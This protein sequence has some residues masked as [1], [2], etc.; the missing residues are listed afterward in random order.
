MKRKLILTVILFAIFLFTGLF[1]SDKTFAA[2]CQKCDG[3]GL[4]NGVSYVGAR[5][6]PDG[7]DGCGYHPDGVG[8]T[9]FNVQFDWG[10]E[11]SD[12]RCSTYGLF[13]CKES[14]QSCATTG[15]SSL[16]SVSYSTSDDNYDYFNVYISNA[17]WMQDV[18]GK[19]RRRKD[20]I[21]IQSKALC[22][23]G[24]D[25]DNGKAMYSKK[26]S[27][28]VDTDIQRKT[29]PNLK[30][31]GGF[32][33]TDF[34]HWDSVCKAGSDKT[35][36]L[37]GKD[38][39]EDMSVFAY[40]I[41]EPDDKYN[42][43]CSDPRSKNYPC[44][45]GSSG[46][47]GETTRTGNSSCTRLFDVDTGETLNECY[48]LLDNFAL[49]DKDSEGNA[50][51]T[52]TL[53]VNAPCGWD[54]WRYTNV[55]SSTD[56]ALL[57]CD[58]N[59]D[60]TFSG[61]QDFSAGYKYHYQ[62]IVH[63]VDADWGNEVSAPQVATV[64]RGGWYSAHADAPSGYVG[65]DW[66]WGY[67]VGFQSLWCPGITV[68]ED[69]EITAYVRR[70]YTLTG[71]AYDLYEQKW[72][73]LNGIC[74]DSSSGFL[75]DWLEVSRSDFSCDRNTL[76]NL[77]DWVGW[78]F[79]GSTC[80]GEQGNEC[81]AVL[82]ADT[83]V[84]AYYE[85]K[86]WEGRI[87][88]SGNTNIKVANSGDGY[89]SQSAEVTGYMDNCENG[90]N[91]TFDSYIKRVSGSGSTK[92]HV[93]RTSSNL[94]SSP[95]AISNADFGEQ[96]GGDLYDKGV[97]ELLRRD[98]ALTM[99]PGMFICEEMTFDANYTNK[100]VHLRLCVFA[101]G[102]AQ[103]NDPANVDTPENDPGSGNLNGD[104][105][106]INIKVKNE[107]VAKWVQY[108]RSVWAKPPYSGTA[109]DRLAYRSSYNP[110]LQYTYYLKLSDRDMPKQFSIDGAGA[111]S[112]NG[113]TIGTL[114]NRNKTPSWNNAYTI[115]RN[116]SGS[117]NLIS[118]NRFQSGV[119][120][121]QS[122]AA[123]YVTV[124]VT[125]AGTAITETAT[126]SDARNVNVRTTPSQVSF[127][128][129]NGNVITTPKSKT[130]FAY[131]PYNFIINNNITSP[132]ES[133]KNDDGSSKTQFFAG[134]KGSIEYEVTINKKKN[135]LTTQNGSD[136]EAY[137]T[138]V[139]NSRTRVIVYYPGA[140]G[141]TKREAGGTMSGDINA[142]VCG[143]YGYTGN[144]DSRCGTVDDG[145]TPQ[146]LPTDVVKKTKNFLV[147]D[148]P[149]GTEICVSVATFPAT[150]GADS[151]YNN[152]SYDNT[153]RVSNSKCY[154]IAKRP[155]LQAWGG[156]VFSGGSMTAS[157]A[158][159]R[160]LFGYTGYSLNNPQGYFVFGSW[161]E[162]G[163]I[164]R[165]EVRGFA[166]GATLGYGA[167]N[168][169]TLTPNPFTDNKVSQ[170]AL[171]QVGGS[172][173]SSFC[174]HSVLT[175]ANSNCSGGV[176]SGTGGKDASDGITLDVSAIESLAGST[177]K[178][179]DL[180]DGSEVVMGVALGADDGVMLYRSGGDLR[181]KEGHLARN[182]FKITSAKNVY[183][184]GNITI[185]DGEKFEVLRQVPKAIIY[186]TDTIYV[187][188][189]VTKLNA[190][191]VANR[192]VTCNNIDTARSNSESLSNRIG[193]KINDRANSK[194][195]VINGAILAGRLYANRTYGAGNGA[196]SV[197][198]A[199]IIDF[200]PTLYLWGGSSGGDSDGSSLNGSIE[201]T[202]LRELAPRY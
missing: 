89:T 143:Y 175:F 80:P 41:C 98:G 84:T 144:D 60:Y 120:S 51:N 93:K 64:E 171:A 38:V 139:R 45:N 85:K 146:T 71:T 108:Q 147:Q 141:V 134:E 52:K 151:N 199:E 184:N 129:T 102:N 122:P 68:N 116:R 103:P 92:Y 78:D 37:N 74:R 119:M 135:S 183:V 106:F 95:R 145:I 174:R 159:K 56:S 123:N 35:C 42:Y 39:N 178:V 26:V 150:S 172:R 180:P 130:A 66:D 73:D 57:A 82:Q 169:L 112:G 197:V 13:T 40:Y 113:Q 61:S 90:C 107:S 188:C 173:E 34:S 4:I 76:E 15:Y 77:Y 9:V 162:L 194:Q 105:A 72:I 22:T 163:V 142:N 10:P 168:G 161:G 75:G 25:I 192:V 30:A 59:H 198:P 6:R 114:F 111:I 100:D 33:V 70:Q 181:V 186:A 94:L 115:Y 53:Q 154:R 153:W 182:I 190:V 44:D 11:C 201:T 164:S 127:S 131:I 55:S 8:A 157:R 29:A 31:G 23:N 140:G 118:E 138:L 12:N 189:D 109:G 195:L 24:Q 124:N 96:I 177:A 133:E 83:D 149:A 187:G 176:A 179:Q 17:G 63:T 193:R 49:D 121:R 165:G 1:L 7:G 202:Y 104:G 32:K 5:A 58:Q 20:K 14:G 67:C 43:P 196:N 65:W 148:L 155:N 136:D 200:D 137:A 21:K 3:S 101:R 156:N 79:H 185:M 87:V 88:A 166:S 16:S 47:G 152:L 99:Y 91:V 125:D 158:M 117:D 28:G 167:K 126:S 2:Q 160:N 69:L 191:L 62:V 27:V 18:A 132:A 86:A 46:G 97:G 54:G 19:I 48:N 128:G 36:E 81:G 110:V 50:L 170:P